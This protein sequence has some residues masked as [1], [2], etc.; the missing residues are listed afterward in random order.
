MSIDNLSGSTASLDY[1]EFRPTLDLNFAR[2]KTLDPRVTFSRSSGGTFVGPDGLIKIAGVNQPRF[3]HNPITGESLGLLIEESRINYASQSFVAINS[4]LVSSNDTTY[5][6]VQ[7][8]SVYRFRIGASGLQFYIPLFNA[9]GYSS[10]GLSDVLT[11]YLRSDLPVTITSNVDGGNALNSGLYFSNGTT[12]NYS[13]SIT[14]Q[15]ELLGFTKYTIVYTALQ[16][17]GNNISR[18]QINVSGTQG[19]DFYVFGAQWESRSIY[20]TSYIPTT[21]A[22]VTR[23]VDVVNMTG[24]NFSSWFNYNSSTLYYEGIVKSD[25]YNGTHSY[26]ATIDSGTND[27]SFY[28]RDR[29]VLSGNTITFQSTLPSSGS[30]VG[31]VSLSYGKPVVNTFNKYVHALDSSGGASASLNGNLG[32]SYFSNS[33]H[34]PNTLQLGMHGTAYRTSCIISRLTYWPRRL[35]NNMLQNL[36]R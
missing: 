14:S 13:T 16:T 36:T 5:Q 15:P 3:D 1:P 25:F 18:A 22:S 28:M 8:G 20:P 31:N 19:T 9:P 27:G 11:F 7:G 23:A 34:V 2:T 21:T 17:N 12:T 10:T 24:S 35:P 32:T 29:I 4:T 30:T 26:I 6:P 33:I